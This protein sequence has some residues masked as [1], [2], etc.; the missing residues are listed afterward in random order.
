MAE[1]KD[2]KDEYFDNQLK[3]LEA[4]IAE[5]KSQLTELERK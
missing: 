3:V 4:M 2:V 1:K 5:T